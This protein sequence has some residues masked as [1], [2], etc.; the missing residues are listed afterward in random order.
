MAAFPRR[1]AAGAIL[2]VRRGLGE[3]PGDVSRCGVSANRQPSGS[4]AAPAD[5][6]ATNMA[7]ALP[8]PA[9]A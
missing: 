4:T 8:S 7:A 6:L 2:G 3:L 1:G 5:G 9:P